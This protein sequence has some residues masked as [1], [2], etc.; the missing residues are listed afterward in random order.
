[1]PMKIGA[2]I[3]K[4]HREGIKFHQIVILSAHRIENSPLRDC[5]VL[6]GVPLEK[7]DPESPGPRNNTLQFSTI[8]R[9]KGL[10]R[11][12]V[13]LIDEMDND[14]AKERRTNLLNVAVT[15]AQHRLFILSTRDDA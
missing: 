14:G 15:R 8:H 13:I 9:F 7:V 5:D 10:E 3:E 6:F 11:D 2:L 4:L 12:V 1:M